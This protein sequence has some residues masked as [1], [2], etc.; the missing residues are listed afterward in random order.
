MKT[1]KIKLIYKC[2]GMYTYFYAIWL[3]L[4]KFSLLIKRKKVEPDTLVRCSIVTQYNRK[5]ESSGNRTDY[6]SGVML[7]I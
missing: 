5:M 3:V 1:L 4:I 7:F 2:K 6:I